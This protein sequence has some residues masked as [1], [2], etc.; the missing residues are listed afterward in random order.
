MVFMPKGQI[1][2]DTQ[3]GQSVVGPIGLPAYQAQYFPVVPKDGKPFN[4][5]YDYV[6]KMSQD[7]LPPARA[8]WSL[9]LY[10]NANGFFIPNTQKK[11]SVGENAG[12]KLNDEGGI[13]IF[14]S[15]EKP[16]DV[17]DENWLPINRDNIDLSLMYRIYAPD[18][19][20]MKIWKMAHPEIIQ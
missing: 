14:I 19:E 7:Q 11:Y 17:P 18:A 3:V 10:D 12:F 9:T 16:E 20:K 15:A 8:F 5:Q 1:D 13:E 6:L 2:L 4:A